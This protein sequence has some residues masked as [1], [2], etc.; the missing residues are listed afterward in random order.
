MNKEKKYRKTRIIAGLILIIII[1]FGTYRILN[2][3]SD[4]SALKGLGYSN[5]LYGIELNPPE[6]WTVD[7]SNPDAIVTFTGPTFENG[8]INIVIAAGQLEPEKTLYESAMEL[9]PKYLDIYIEEYTIISVKNRTI[10]SMNAFEIIYTVIQNEVQ[11]KQKQVWI[12]KSGMTLILSY[13]AFL[14]VFDTY[15]TV[16]EESLS[17]VVIL[18]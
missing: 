8:T 4:N 12:E 18:W 11:A 16:F 3:R 7:E 9:I 17:S 15:N 13:G 1:L 10:N 5:T 14:D 6:G 2:Y